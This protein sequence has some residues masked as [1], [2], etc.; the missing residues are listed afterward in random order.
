MNAS[1][2]LTRDARA[3]L[4]MVALMVALPDDLLQM[5][6]TAAESQIDDSGRVHQN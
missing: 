5:A 3:P 4:D 2:A 1:C 6:A